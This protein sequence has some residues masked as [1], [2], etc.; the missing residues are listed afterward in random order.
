[1]GGKPGTCVLVTRPEPGATR[2]VSALLER[3]IHAMAVCL[4]QILPLPTEVPG[5]GFDALI[6]TS[7]NGVRHGAALLKKYQ[8]LPVFVV[9]K[10]TSD[11]LKENGHHEVHW[12]EN[13]QSLLALI[14]GAAP[15]HLLYICGQT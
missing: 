5:I 3:G 13:A 14:F 11:I 6:V 12:A 1:M 4:T 9:G 7:Q 8:S 10:R 2:T 15:E